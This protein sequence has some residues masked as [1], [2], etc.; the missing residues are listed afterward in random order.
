MDFKDKLFAILTEQY[1]PLLEAT[2]D[3]RKNPPKF[4]AEQDDNNKKLFGTVGSVVAKDFKKGIL[5]RIHRDDPVSIVK[6]AAAYGIAGNKNYRNS[7][8]VG[9][10]RKVRPTDIELLTDSKNNTVQLIFRQTITHKREND[11]YNENVRDELYKPG[12]AKKV[13]EPVAKE[14]VKTLEAAGATDVTTNVVDSSKQHGYVI[15][16]KQLDYSKLKNFGRVMS[17]IV[18][19][20]ET[21][22]DRR[23]A[24]TSE[25]ELSRDKE[26]RRQDTDKLAA[27]KFAD[28]V[29]K[30]VIAKEALEKNK[31]YKKLAE[32]L[33]Q[34]GWKPAGLTQ[35]K[36][37]YAASDRFGR[38]TI[39]ATIMFSNG[40]KQ[41]G[42][43]S[44]FTGSYNVDDI[45]GG[46]LKRLSIDDLF[47]KLDM[48]R[49]RGRDVNADEFV[50][51]DLIEMNG[52]LDSDETK[53]TYQQAKST[54]S[55]RSLRRILEDTIRQCKLYQF[56]EVQMRASWDSL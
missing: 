50:F 45:T 3:V 46:S 56:N 39:A 4:D 51:Y 15:K 36:L 1:D 43:T 21:S 25:G 18:K 32:V 33:E 31:V 40:T 35:W 9:E 52:R 2:A 19:Q 53:A 47:D 49:T 12:V 27:N 38:V 42:L 16:F 30:T 11:E 13:L 26:E 28:K 5:R 24:D 10:S 41:Y 22:D 14:I 54:K 55:I 34:N 29:A 17:V 8:W 20:P 44:G 48:Y 23:N 6:F 7:I 37:N